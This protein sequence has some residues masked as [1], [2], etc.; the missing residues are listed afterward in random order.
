MKQAP[1]AYENRIGIRPISWEDFHG[2]CKSLASAAADFRPQ[3]I[4]AVGRAGYYPGTLIAHMLQTEIFPVRVSRRVND[5]IRY[6]RPK[7]IVKPPK[8]VKDRRVLIVDEIC[9]SGE[10]LQKVK[11]RAEKLGAKAVR[12]AVL[13]SHTH[14]QN[15]P[16]YIGL[17]TDELVLNPWDREIYREGAFIMHPEYVGALEAQGIEPDESLLINAPAFEPMKR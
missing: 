13:Y 5:E 8:D 17:I 10:T 7:W 12:T 16:D 6:K 11:K 1:Y 4:L 2:L 3:I 9:D 15:I 14:G